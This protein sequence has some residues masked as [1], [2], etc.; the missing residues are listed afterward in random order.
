L[1]IDA[2]GLP[3]RRMEARYGGWCLVLSDETVGRHDVFR[4]N[5]ADRNDFPLR[6]TLEGMIR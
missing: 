3:R 4:K 2:K 5:R 1:R 6:T